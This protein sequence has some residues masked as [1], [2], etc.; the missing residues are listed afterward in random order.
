MIPG[1]V[2]LAI[3]LGTTAPA[4]AAPDAAWAPVAFE[5]A[6]AAWDRCA[7]DS[8]DPADRLLAAADALGPLAPRLLATRTADGIRVTER[9]SGR[10]LG[11]L[12]AR[13]ADELAPALHGL[14]RLAGPLAGAVSDT[15]V[16]H[17]LLEGAARAVD[18]WARVLDDGDAADLQRRLHGEVGR[19]PIT[20]AQDAGGWVVTH[21]WS[22]AEGRTRLGPG[23][24][25]S[26]IDGW[27]AADRGDQGRHLE[28]PVGRPAVLDVV[29]ADGGAPRRVVVPRDPVR[30]PSVRATDHG[31]G[32][33]AVRLL[34]LTDGTADELRATWSAVRQGGAPIAGLVVDLRGLSG[35]TLADAA[36]VLDVLRPA[37][38]LGRLH[39]KDP[40]CLDEGNAPFASRD[41]GTEP[42]APM[43]VWIDGGTA[44]AGEWIAAVLRAAGAP[45]VGMPSHGKDQVQRAVQLDHGTTLRHT[46]A[47]I[48]P[49]SG[50]P[51]GDVGLTPD[52]HAVV[53]GEVPHARRLPERAVHVVADEDALAVLSFRPMPPQPLCATV[54]A[55]PA[56]A[57]AVPTG[58]PP[59]HHW[60]AGPVPGPVRAGWSSAPTAHTVPARPVLLADGCTPHVDGLRLP[61]VPPPPLVPFT[62]QRIGDT[63]RLDGAPDHPAAS[64]ALVRRRARPSRE[65][66]FGWPDGLGRVE[67]PLDAEGSTGR[68]LWLV[69]RDDRWSIRLPIGALG[70]A[71]HTIVPPHIEAPGATG[72]IAGPRAAWPVEVEVDQG[73]IQVA[74]RLDDRV[75]DW[76]QGT[77]RVRA[78][79]SLPLA[80]LSG[81]HRLTVEVTTSD[82]VTTARTWWIAAAP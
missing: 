76:L 56:P 34:A 25:V 54:P 7:L 2:A 6:A 37:G 78:D 28:G 55:H 82:G 80:T 4:S 57:G 36:A 16:R 81:P 22:D 43:A 23:D 45:L 71:P 44:S 59:T 68:D 29:P 32:L 33:I 47:R 30:I 65:A 77:T 21:G 69:G 35:G 70:T 13:T 26:A 52:R 64:V 15:V 11:R 20:I 14:E 41:D 50:E 1:V 48:L 61:T 40:S 72:W 27:R 39:A 3:V 8:V 67:V 62:V 60:V 51:W 18:P 10:L 58:R 66:P 74:V 73:P 53:V 38:T 19:A 42:D 75:M 79:V 12:R 5:R 17:T 46:V 31:N 9:G 63:V 24:R 49:P